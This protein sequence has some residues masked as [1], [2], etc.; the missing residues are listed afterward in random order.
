MQRCR[1]VEES[2]V[3]GA[4]LVYQFS[5]PAELNIPKRNVFRNVTSYSP[6]KVNWHFAGTYASFFRVKE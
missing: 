2:S 5:S 1:L 4:T 3:G 6:L